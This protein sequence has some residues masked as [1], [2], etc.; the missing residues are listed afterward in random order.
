M[1]GEYYINFPNTFSMK[2]GKNTKDT[3]ISEHILR[4]FRN[5]LPEINF[6]DYAYWECE[7]NI[8]KRL[9]DRPPLEVTQINLAHIVSV[10]YPKLT[11]FIL[12]EVSVHKL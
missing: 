4:K 7:F 12:V 3:A 10:G 5:Y 1:K 9:D 8:N 6:F 11:T 2:C